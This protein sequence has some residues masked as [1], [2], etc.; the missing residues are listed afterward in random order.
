MKA[1][2]KSATG[3]RNQNTFHPGS[4]IHALER[5]SRQPAELPGRPKL[6]RY[7]PRGPGVP[8]SPAILTP[9]RGRP[10]VWHVG[11]GRRNGT[12]QKQSFGSLTWKHHSA[13]SL[14]EHSLLLTAKYRA[15]KG[16]SVQSSSRV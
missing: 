2:V 11:K 5:E 1:P 7:G 12:S 8:A 13:A 10:P 16:L 15:A 3:C 4:G 9:R 6:Q 14:C